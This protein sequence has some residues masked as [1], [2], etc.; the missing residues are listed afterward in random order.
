[1]LPCVESLSY[2]PAFNFARA[3]TRS[4]DNPA[5][6]KF[7]NSTH[8]GEITLRSR[9]AKPTIYQ[10]PRGLCV[11]QHPRPLLQSPFRAAPGLTRVPHL[12]GVCNKIRGRHFCNAASILAF[13]CARRS[14]VRKRNPTCT[15]GCQRRRRRR[16][17]YFRR[18]LEL[19]AGR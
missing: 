9:T 12:A 14:S 2:R 11:R 7:Q 16:R 19:L 15:G 4:Y 18:K 13:F 5:T 1:M 10:C 6:T 3:T 8:K 17:H